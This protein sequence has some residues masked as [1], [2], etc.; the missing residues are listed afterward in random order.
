MQRRDALRAAALGTL[1][2]LASGWL[3]PAQAQ[4]SALN[5][6]MPIGGG[7]G[8]DTSTRL[9]A[10]VIGREL[11]RSVVIENKPGADTMI[12]TQHV[13][14][15]SSDGSR[16]LFTSPSNMVIV[17]LVNKRLNFN[18]AAQLQPVITAMRGGTSLVVK[19][20]RFKD[21]AEFVA[22]AKRAPG[23]V[24]LATYGGH[25]YKLLGLMI[26]RELG[27]EL[28]LAPYK[29]PAPAVNDVVGGNVDA[30][31]SDAS[32]AR[33]FFRAGKTH[34]LAQTH[35][36]RPQAFHDVPTFQELGHPG[37][38]AYIWTG[39]AVKAGTPPEVVAQLYQSF[40]RALKSKEYVDYMAANSSGA[41]V[42]D[43]DPEQTRQY[44]D[45]ERKRFAALIDKTGYTA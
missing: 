43:L 40:S 5:V 1:G 31:L 19:S 16:V 28:N 45:A 44:L 11:K 33:E 23:Q 38:V 29:D 10:D 27:I 41:E 22:A 7:T 35:G 24:S 17:P 25:Y 42:V 30:M 39:F 20:G 8:A 3:T 21:L 15:G 6:I 26:Q 32:G 4:A 18:P 2:G 37:L 12:A 36:R 34:I 14:S 13:L 9:L